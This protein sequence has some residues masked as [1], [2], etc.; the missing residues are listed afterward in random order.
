MSKVWPYEI[1]DMS[2]FFKMCKNTTEKLQMVL[3][4]RWSTDEGLK[5][6]GLSGLIQCGAPCRKELKIN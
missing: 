3:P 6:N 4:G 5:W 2:N 1:M